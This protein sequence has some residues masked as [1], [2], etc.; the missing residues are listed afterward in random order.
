MT[1]CP[2]INVASVACWLR[3]GLLAVFIGC[4][5]S[6]CSYRTCSCALIVD[7]C[8]DF[9]LQSFEHNSRASPSIRKRS[10]T[11]FAPLHTFF[12]H[13][14]QSAASHLTCL[15]TPAR[16]AHDCTGNRIR[17]IDHRFFRNCRTHEV[18]SW[19]LFFISKTFLVFRENHTT[20]TVSFLRRH[21]VLMPFWLR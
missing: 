4:F 18:D 11:S 13:T 2:A 6:D 17:S 12:F 5:L 9:P 8:T 3:V 7:R 16:I 10:H 1:S 14:S 15:S 20:T 21:T 19:A